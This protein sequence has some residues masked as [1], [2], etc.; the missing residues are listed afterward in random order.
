MLRFVGD[1]LVMGKGRTTLKSWYRSWLQSSPRMIWENWPIFEVEDCTD[2]VKDKSVQKRY[3]DTL[4]L[5]IGLSECSA[6][7]VPRETSAYSSQKKTWMVM[8]RSLQKGVRKA[9]SSFLYIATD[10]CPY[11][12]VVTSMLSGNVKYPSMKLPKPAL[13]GLK[14]LIASSLYASKLE[15]WRSTQL[16]ALSMQ[17]RAA[18][19]TWTKIVNWNYSILRI[20]F[21]VSYKGSAEESYVEHHCSWVYYSFRMRKGANLAFMD[22]SKA[23]NSSGKA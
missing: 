21:D 23:W 3:V 11:I 1:L 19:K 15:H 20:C 2:F 16:R 7:S 5:D 14:Y 17:I 4:V 6:S 22:G 9:T 12:A 18:T 13:K 8:T 10:S